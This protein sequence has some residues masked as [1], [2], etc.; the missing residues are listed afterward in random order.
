MKVKVAPSQRYIT[1]KVAYNMHSLKSA[2]DA[3]TKLGKLHLYAQKKIRAPP[4]AH[5]LWLR[6]ALTFVPDCI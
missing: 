1:N 3:K 2:E 4:E 5:K 6:Y